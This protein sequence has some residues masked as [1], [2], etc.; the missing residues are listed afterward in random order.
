[1]WKRGGTARGGGCW[2]RRKVGGMGPVDSEGRDLLS[3]P[4]SVFAQRSSQLQKVPA[5]R[6]IQRA[7]RG[8]SGNKTLCRCSCILNV[9]DSE[10]KGGDSSW[11]RFPLMALTH[12]GRRGW[13]RERKNRRR[14][15]TGLFWGQEAFAVWLAWWLPSRVESL[16]QSPGPVLQLWYLTILF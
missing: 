3:D 9:D 7:Q 11:G 12:P 14:M 13:N 16:R 6:A 1:M 8:S 5:K 4:L 15:E 10:E 2:L